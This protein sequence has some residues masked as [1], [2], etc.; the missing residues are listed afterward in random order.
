MPR[1]LKNSL[2]VLIIVLLL[3]LGVTAG[4]RYLV[5]ADELGRM[6]A[7]RIAKSTGAA[8]E[9]SGIE[10]TFWPRLRLVVHNGLVRG[11]GAALAAHTGRPTPL[12]EYLVAVGRVEIDVAVAPLLRRRIETGKLRLVEPRIEVTTVA[13]TAAPSR[14]SAPPEDGGAS[15]SGAAFLV[16]GVGIENGSL[17]WTDE[18]AGRELK[19]GGWNQQVGLSEIGALA[20]RLKAVTAGG[21]V[22]TAGDE[23][24]TLDLRAEI[25]DLVLTGFA[26]SGPVV[27]SAVRVEGGMEIS[28]AADRIE[29]E[30]AEAS[31]DE[32]RLVASGSAVP[33]PDGGM[34]IAGDWEMAPAGLPGLVASVAAATT[35]PP[36]PA[37]E[38][39]AS[40][41]VSA[42]TMAAAGSFDL[43]WP[44]ADP[45]DPAAL[46]SA[47][48]LE[49]AVEGLRMTPPREM[50]EV[51]ADAKFSLSGGVLKMTGL[52][53]SADGGTLTGE[54][55]L[56]YRS[57]PRG[58]YAFTADCAD[59]PVAALLKPYARKAAAM[60]EGVAV[61]RLTGGGVLGDKQTVLNSLSVDGD[62]SLREGVVHATDL[63]AGVSRYLG[64]RQDLKEI[65]YRELLHHVH[66]ADGRYH[67]SD[68]RLSGPD[69]D[70]EGGGSI[71]FTGDL[72]LDLAVRLP[73]GFTPDLGD[74]TPMAEALRGDDGRIRLDL[75]LSGPARRPNVSLKLDRAQEKITEK[76]TEGL[77]GWLDKLKGRK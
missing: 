27:L 56:D 12:K 38:W 18:V 57:D 51:A 19:I 3:A 24:S 52:Q 54:G 76:V 74:M 44:L 49:G 75:N 10:L 26:E 71:G 48:T 58:V 61:G 36:G 47:L 28:P 72:D 7:G 59:M 2:R 70:W 21:E 46:L 42:G 9:F 40:D 62:L 23:A 13:E 50:P 34:R 30:L 22:L 73:A 17:V 60:I 35:L 31:W 67:L 15:A 43:A 33:V 69:T 41:P 29:F 8:V 25:G 64:V 39:L 14:A 45:A 20:A 63:L 65:R 5:P 55:T 4:L 1:I 6:A 32:V 11:T 16:A 77:K 68:L 53:A 37:A 66:V